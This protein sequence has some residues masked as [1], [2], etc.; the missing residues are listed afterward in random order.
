MTLKLTSTKFLIL[1]G[2]YK[3]TKFQNGI[4]RRIEGG[5][6]SE[7][8]RELALIYPDEKIND[9]ALNK[10]IHFLR[11]VQA[12]KQTDK[13][14]NGRSVMAYI[15]NQEEIFSSLKETTIFTQT[16]EIILKIGY[17]GNPYEKI[18]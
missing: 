1:I 14:I 13:R 12:I 5:S 7:I 16:K 15:I 4:T 17:I 3:L 8:R 9:A 10:M 11:S 18:S 6:L 2:L